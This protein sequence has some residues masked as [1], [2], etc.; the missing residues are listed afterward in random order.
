[1]DKLKVLYDKFSDHFIENGVF[2]SF[3][4][5]C[6]TLSKNDNRFS[7]DKMS[8][9]TG[10]IIIGYDNVRTCLKFVYI[11]SINKFFNELKN[12]TTDEE[13]YELI[14]AIQDK[15]EN[16][17]KYFVFAAFEYNENKKKLMEN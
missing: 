3:L 6:N 12:E 15:Q 9:K 13:L 4:N 17:F 7:F 2:E 1:M 11:K 10:S 8:E 16:T 5:Q 14:K